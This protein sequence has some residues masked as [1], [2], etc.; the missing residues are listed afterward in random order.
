MVSER[1]VG[2]SLTLIIF[3]YSKRPVKSKPWRTW[4]S[5]QHSKQYAVFWCEKMPNNN[6]WGKSTTEYFSVVDYEPWR[7]R[8]EI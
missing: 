1:I 5:K 4:L 7:T 8:L 3:K 6:V 2:G